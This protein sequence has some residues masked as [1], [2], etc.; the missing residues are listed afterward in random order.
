MT[1]LISILLLLALIGASLLW[2]AAGQRRNERHMA[3]EMRR[4][5]LRLGITVAVVFC[6]LALTGCASRSRVA[7]ASL[8]AGALSIP[9]QREVSSPPAFPRDGIS[10]VSQASLPAGEIA[11]GAA[12]ILPGGPITARL[13]WSQ[14]DACAGWTVFGYSNGVPV[15]VTN[16]ARP[17]Y[18]DTWQ[19][20]ISSPFIYNT[21]RSY[22]R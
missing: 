5:F 15:V 1:L 19:F 6:A 3:S 4:K 10:A 20:T 8:P 22:T 21:V 16:I 2:V 13:Q 17:I 18:G 12:N 11:G 14:P 9:A 7:Q